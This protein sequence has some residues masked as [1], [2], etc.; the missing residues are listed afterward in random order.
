MEKQDLEQYDPD[1]DNVPAS[2]WLSSIDE[3]HAEQMGIRALVPGIDVPLGRRPDDAP[4]VAKLAKGLAHR[5]RVE[6]MR[7]LR[8]EGALPYYEI[9]R[10]IPRAP[11][12][13]W[14]HLKI[15][16]RADLIECWID[17]RGI[18]YRRKQASVRKLARF[19]LRL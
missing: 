15:L 7:M 11:S 18:V 14:E 3:R 13:V 19:V 12:T 17:E 6:I 9:A 16:L 5:H 8:R 1:P 2:A 4:D 10:R